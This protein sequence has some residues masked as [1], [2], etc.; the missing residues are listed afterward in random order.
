MP[1]PVAW[2]AV[3]TVAATE[4]GFAGSSTVSEGSLPFLKTS[5]ALPVR[6]HETDTVIKGNSLDAGWGRQPPFPSHCNHAIGETI[7]N[8][9]TVGRVVAFRRG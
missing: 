5:A 6:H 7:G 8:T 3:S 9:L 1:W 2:P 4:R